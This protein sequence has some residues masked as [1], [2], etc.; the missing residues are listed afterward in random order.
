MI[1]RYS[2]PEMSKVWEP[3]ARFRIWLEIETLAAEAM[4]NLGQIPKSVPKAVRKK[5]NFDIA[6]IEIGRAHV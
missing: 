4:A 6:R 5:G 3:E 1:P 2:R